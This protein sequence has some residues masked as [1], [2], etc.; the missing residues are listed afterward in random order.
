MLESDGELSFD[1][2]NKKPSEE[3]DINWLYVSNIYA[4]ERKKEGDISGKWLIYVSTENV[5]YYWN[6]IIEAAKNREIRNAKVSTIGKINKTKYNSHVICVYCLESNSQK[7]R[8]SLYK[9]G[10]NS[11]IHFKS[12]GNAKK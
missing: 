4:R 7:V 5:D 10:F 11:L 12:H 3:T 8:D 1:F 6:K 2:G 9:Y